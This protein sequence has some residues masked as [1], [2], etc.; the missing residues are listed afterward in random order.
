LTDA[1]LRVL[2]EGDISDVDLDMSYDELDL[3][4]GRMNMQ[5]P[6]APWLQDWTR[7]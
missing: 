3:V 4:S 1:E 6:Q 5:S 2:L 7:K